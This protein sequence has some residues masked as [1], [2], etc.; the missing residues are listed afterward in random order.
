MDLVFNKRST[1]LGMITGAVA[2]LVAITPAS[3][4]VTPIASIIIGL[5]AGAIC[6]VSVSFC[7]AK[8][9][10]D[11]SLDAFGVHG[12]GGIWGAVATGL[13]AT[14]IVNPGGSD[15]FFYG[16]PGQLMIQIKAILITMLYSFIVSY[17]L[18]WIVDKL[19]G[20][21]AGEHEERVGLD[22]SE[23]REAAYT[24]LE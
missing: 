16:N 2:G 23:H 21:R 9:G 7:K 6:Y 13:F 12:V 11:D 19:F 24:T 22:L 18:F 14:K 4:F 15:G 17:V 1:V 8:W 5:G 20:L 3:G 10:Y